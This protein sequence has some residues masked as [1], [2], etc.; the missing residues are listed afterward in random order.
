MDTNQ[1]AAGLIRV[2]THMHTYMQAGALRLRAALSRA[3]SFTKAGCALNPSKFE[4]STVE[5]HGR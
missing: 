1:N 2:E 3:L 4:Q 5:F